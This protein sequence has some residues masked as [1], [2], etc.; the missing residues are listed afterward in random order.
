[1][2]T[3]EIGI[4][5]YLIGLAVTAILT[6]ISLDTRGKSHERSLRVSSRLQL[7]LAALKWFVARTRGMNA[8][9]FSYAV[10]NCC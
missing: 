9:T 8:P 2:R 1:M 6:L 7:R 3:M 10:P 4:A 5:L